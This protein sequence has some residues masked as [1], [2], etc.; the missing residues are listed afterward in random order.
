M[1]VQSII[2]YCY[3]VFN[4]LQ[5]FYFSD[6]LGDSGLSIV[7]I[8]MLSAIDGKVDKI[9]MSWN[10]DVVSTLTVFLLP[11]P[12]YSGYYITWNITK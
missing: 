8:P 12:G 4:I 10:N 1:L 3:G 2:F 7:V 5:I 11:I 6:C 9:A